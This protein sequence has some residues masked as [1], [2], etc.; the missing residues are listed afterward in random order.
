MV[1]IRITGGIGRRRQ[2]RIGGAT[3]LQDE[4]IGVIGS[5]SRALDSS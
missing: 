3:F 2:A 5:S 1:V 4:R